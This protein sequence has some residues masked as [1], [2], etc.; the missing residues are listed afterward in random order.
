M[1]SVA[2]TG[3]IFYELIAAMVSVVAVYDVICVDV[4]MAL[5]WLQH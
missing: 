5:F 4:G 1:G 2:N 3:Y